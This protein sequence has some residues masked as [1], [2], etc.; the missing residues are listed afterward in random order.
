MPIE[1]LNNLKPYPVQE[2][3]LLKFV[4]LCCA[5]NFVSSTASLDGFNECIQACDQFAK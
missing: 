3:M 2:S 1:V 4:Y 5:Q